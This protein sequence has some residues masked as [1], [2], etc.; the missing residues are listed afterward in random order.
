MKKLLLLVC[1]AAC[2]WAYAE[3]DYDSAKD[4]MGCGTVVSLRPLN[5]RPLMSSRYVASGGGTSGIAGQL[6]GGG[7]IGWGAALVLDLGVSLWQSE[8]RHRAVEEQHRTKKYEDVMAV[9]FRFDD[10]RVVNLPMVVF[11]GMRYREGVRL[12]AYYSH[13]HGN[14][15][16]GYN[17]LFD[18][19]ALPDEPGYLDACSNMLSPEQTNSLLEASAYL[20]DETKI[21][22]E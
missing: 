14:L 16:L 9:Q 11:S 1:L 15:Q 5:Q 7:V 4:R 10:G 18:S 6:A 2:G 3:E 19:V 21:I 22:A 12:K 17:A 13:L 20:V 8:A